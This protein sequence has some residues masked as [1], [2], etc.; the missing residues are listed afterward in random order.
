[1]IKMGCKEAE[2]FRVS[3]S[4]PLAG[5]PT[6]RYYCGDLQRRNKKQNM[7]DR[8]RVLG[9]QRV[10]YSRSHMCELP[11][12]KN[13]LLIDKSAMLSP[14]ALGEG[15]FLRLQ[16]VS[17]S[18]SAL[19]LHLGPAVEQPLLL[20]AALSPDQTVIISINIIPHRKDF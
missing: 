5:C 10:C 14:W 13:N 18:L 17:R 2:V 9:P 4:Y 11:C 16:S 7:H 12:T 19:C 6:L 20:H 15:C 3:V 8:T 1:M